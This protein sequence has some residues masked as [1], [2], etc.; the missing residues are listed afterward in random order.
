MSNLLNSTFRYYSNK[1]PEKNQLVMTTIVDLNMDTSIVKVI[2][3]EYSNLEAIVNLS[4]FVKKKK[5]QAKIFIKLGQNIP[6]SVLSIDPK[7]GHILLS[8][9]MISTNEVTKFEEDYKYA[10]LLHKISI[11]L[12][13]LYLKFC[14][15]KNIIVQDISTFMTNTIWK[16]YDNEDED[17]DIN[18]KNLYYSILQNYLQLIPNFDDNFRTI[19]NNNFD[20]R[21][22]KK[23]LISTTQIYLRS[24]SSSGINVIKNILNIDTNICKIK[25]ISASPIYTIML[26][27]ID[28]IKIN[29][30]IDEL[31]VLI[32]QRAQNEKCEYKLVSKNVIQKEVY[33]EIKYLAKSDIDKICF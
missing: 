19:V 15:D 25:I 29:N 8:K 16:L 2:L 31:I 12:W 17:E 14:Q 27:D 33:N 6:M 30:T 10:T 26:Y 21:I 5:G 22:I 20:S 18:Y 23:E 28:E 3:P 4:E 24:F 9:K 7:K 32:E 11:E 13:N 1:Y